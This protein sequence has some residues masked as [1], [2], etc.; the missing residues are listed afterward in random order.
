MRIN[1]N[2]Q[3]LNAYRNLAQN[4]FNT[5]KSFEKLSSGLRINRAADDAAGLAISEKMRSQIRGLEMSERNA[6]DAISLIQTAEG[7]LNET[8]SILQRMR[9]LS[10][11]AGNDTLE[12]QDREAIQ[13]EVDQLTKELDRIAGTTQFNRKELLRGAEGGRAFAS[14]SSSQVTYK[15]AATNTWE[16]I[17]TADPT[18]PASVELNFSHKIGELPKATIDGKTFTINGKVYEID[19]TDDPAIKGLKTS[20]NIAVNVIGWTNSTADDVGAANINKLLTV[21]K[22]AIVK[23]DTTFSSSSTVSNAVNTDTTNNDVITN[24]K[25]TLVTSNN[26]SVEEAGKIGVTSSITSTEGLN[27]YQPGTTSAISKLYAEQS[28]DFGKT[29][30]ITFG[31]T[32]KDG[33]K[34][35]IDNLEITFTDGKSG[36][37]TG[38]VWSGTKGTARI[39]INNKSIYDVLN[40]IES[41]MKVAEKHVNKP[42]RDVSAYSIIGNSLQLTTMDTKNGTSFTN[43]VNNEGL[44]IQIIDND[45][46]ATAGNDLT[47]GMQIGPNASER[48]DISIG[49]MDTAALGLAFNADDTPITTPGVNAVKGIDVSSS[50]AAAQVAIS[51]IDN[52]ITMVSAERSNLGAFQNRLEHTINNLKATNENLT[53]S[54]SRIRDV[55][56]A[57]EMTTFTKNN[58]LNQSAQAMLA[59]A[60]QLPQGILQLLQ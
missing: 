10:V 47:L 20:S 26:M 35:R 51:A 56:M 9:E 8:H 38:F 43:N 17:V 42:I 23:N 33:D 30:Y 37:P 49:V 48:I 44:E 32:P 15:G 34:L 40:N 4:Q 18:D 55:D 52:A 22:N 57:L 41:V 58:I 46:E 29:S 14:I 12:S 19:I 7:A 50:S 28:A 31:Q 13:T 16:G 24:G 45:F 25:L 53:S 21:L 5:S 36:T 27:L 6:L 54:E 3:A 2:I 39:D 11:Q 1:H 59:Q 60:N